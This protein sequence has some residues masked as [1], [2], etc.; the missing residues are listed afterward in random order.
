MDDGLLMFGGFS[1]DELAVYD[2]GVSQDTTTYPGSQILSYQL[3]NYDT[4]LLISEKF[5]YLHM[6]VTL[7]YRLGRNVN[8]VGGFKVSRLISAPP[9]A[10]TP[11]ILFR[12]GFNNGSTADAEV[13]KSDLID[14]GVVRRWD[15]APLVGLS[16]DMGRRFALDIQ[17]QFGLIPYIDRPASNREDYNR[18]LSLGLRYRVL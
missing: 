17:Y 9:V 18:S 2:P 13:A 4:A 7:E 16:V 6:P 15:I 14:E 3:L 8:L 12:S 1:Q 10:E 11:D 5:N